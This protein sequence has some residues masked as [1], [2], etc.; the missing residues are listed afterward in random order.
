MIRLL[1]DLFSEKGNI[2][3]MRL[4]SL[5]SVVAAIVIAILGI[6]HE[7]VDYSGLTLLCSAFLGAGFT[8]KV[9]QKRFENVNRTS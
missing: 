6:C 9:I 7:S 2:S 4:L 1:K 5:M 3:M 8:G